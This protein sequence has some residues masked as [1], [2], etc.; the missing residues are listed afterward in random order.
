[1]RW[2]DPVSAGWLTANIATIWQPADNWQIVASLENLFDKRYRVHGSGIDA[3][4]RNLLLSLHML[5]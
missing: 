4:G 2:S 3:T 1:L 5:W